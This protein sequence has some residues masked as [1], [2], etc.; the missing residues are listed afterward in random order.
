MVNKDEHQFYN[1]THSNHER[2]K[3]PGWSQGIV[4]G[5]V[6]RLVLSILKFY[7][8]YITIVSHHLKLQELL[9]IPNY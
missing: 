4:I 9:T 6:H 7:I 5:E 8:Y 3:I 2:E 1:T